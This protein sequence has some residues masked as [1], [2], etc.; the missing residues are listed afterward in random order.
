MP[1]N[2]SKCTR[3]GVY[4]NSVYSVIDQMPYTVADLQDYEMASQ[5]VRNNPDR[6]LHVASVR[7][8]AVKKL[9]QRELC[10]YCHKAMNK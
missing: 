6:R 4:H 3:C 5:L 7:V 2:Q 9:G 8:R 10:Q 1:K